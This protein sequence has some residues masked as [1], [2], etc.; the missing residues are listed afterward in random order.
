MMTRLFHALRNLVR[1][2][3]VERDLD[4]EL[5]ASFDLLVEENT[6][7]GMRPDEARRT[8]ANR[9]ACRVGEGAGA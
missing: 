2:D 8:A 5:R 4:E 7:A 1:R 3:R 6:R 9:A